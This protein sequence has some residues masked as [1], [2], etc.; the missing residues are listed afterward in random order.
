MMTHHARLNLIM[1]ATVAGLVVFL[2]FRPQS[3]DIP[4]YSISSRPVETVQNLRIIRQQKEIVL[5]QLDN[6]WR[7]I[8]PVQVCADDK[9]IRE[10]LEILT[11]SSHHRFPLTDLERFGLDQPDMRLYINDEYFG[12]GGFAPITYQQYVATGDDIY[13][14]SSRYALTLP[15]SASD[16]INPGLL[17]SHQIPVKFEMSRLTVEF[18]NENWSSRVQDSDKALNGEAIEHW[19][20]L[21][22]TALAQEITL[23]HELGA[24]FTETDRIKISLQDTQEINLKVLQNESEIVLVRVNEGIG[25]HFPVDTGR[26]LIDPY[27]LTINQILP[28]N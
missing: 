25:Y 28:D 21:W 13:L 16:L 8:E 22:Q 17:A 12:F 23:N 27:M 20:R 26:Q 6:R 2:Y 1:F 14:I 10:I 7:M 5:E 19:V 18:K 11:A 15:V 3:Q 24:D 4:E 9:K